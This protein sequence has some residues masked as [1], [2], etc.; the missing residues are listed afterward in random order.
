MISDRPC[1]LNGALYTG[2][3]RYFLTTCVALRRRVFTSAPISVRLTE[4][5]LHNA[6]LF[7]FAVPA[8]CIM[9]DHMHALVEA[10]RV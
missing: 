6:R 7:E 8:Y 4:L 9:P 10:Q 3:Q 1:R 5:L 2:C